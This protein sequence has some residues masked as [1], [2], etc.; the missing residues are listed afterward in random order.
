[1]RGVDIYDLH[2]FG[3]CNAFERMKQKSQ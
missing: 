1:M 3:Y 2:F